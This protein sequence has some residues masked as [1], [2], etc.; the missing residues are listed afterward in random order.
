MGTRNPQAGEYSLDSVPGVIVSIPPQ[1]VGA[2]RCPL[3]IFPPSAYDARQVTDWLR[4]V[5]AK[6]G[7]IL[8]APSRSSA[9][10]IDAALKETLQKFAIDPEK[11]AIV[12]RCGSG[13]TLGIDNLDVFSRVVSISGIDF[14]AGIGWSSKIGRPSPDRP[15]EFLFDAG[16]LESSDNFKAVRELRESGHAV[17]QI[18]GLRGHEHQTEDYDFVG[19][20][21]QESWTKPPAMRTLPSVIADPL[22]PLTTDVVAR[23]TTFWTSFQK[24]PDSIRTVARRAHLREVVVPVGKERPSIVMTDMPVLA[25]QYPSVAAALKAAGLTAQQHDIYRVALISAQVTKNVEGAA[26]VAEKSS[27]LTKNV[28][29]LEEHPAE[30]EMLA[31]AG[32]ENPDGWRMITHPDLVSKVGPLGIWRTP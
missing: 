11:I 15:T 21:L 3:F 16:F 32:V 17:K 26:G 4:P 18:M 25:A 12:G 29:F 10:I 27:V 2:R 1:C 13:G 19:R 9:S 31:E 30:F 8:L 6:Y 5:A 23:M 24:E 20:W 28:A 22:P 14:T 7:M